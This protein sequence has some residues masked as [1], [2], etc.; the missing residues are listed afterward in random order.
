[1]RD[2]LQKLELNSSDV[3]I[4]ILESEELTEM[5][6]EWYI[7]ATQSL[8]DQIKA[9]GYPVDVINQ[10]AREFAW[11]NDG[12]YEAFTWARDALDRRAWELGLRYTNSD[13]TS[14][15]KIDTHDG[16]IT[17][18]VTEEEI[19]EGL[20]FE[21]SW[22]DN[23]VKAISPSK[24]AS[25]QSNKEYKELR[26]RLLMSFKRRFGFGRGE[27]QTWSN[28]LRWMEQSN[29]DP[30]FIN[31]YADK[32][33]KTTRFNKKWPLTEEDILAFM[34]GLAAEIMIEGGLD[35]VAVGSY[36]PPTQKKEKSQKTKISQQE[37]EELENQVKTLNMQEIDDVFEK[38]KR[39]EFSLDPA[40]LSRIAKT[41][42]VFSEILRKNQ[43]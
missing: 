1:M 18:T 2:I 15:T 25:I 23:I 13:D 43:D 39:G 34:A 16:I 40:E 28:L 6:K 26:Q 5:H 9:G 22:I 8:I 3:S 41:I 42:K 7:N 21:L 11:K 20:L 38:L 31:Y 24:Y 10:L 37:K 14:Y 4:T 32:F 27:N 35:N 12:S 30:K 33:I 19:K 36:N 17:P 29:F